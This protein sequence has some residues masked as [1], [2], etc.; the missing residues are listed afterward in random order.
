MKN[1]S[2]WFDAYDWCILWC[3]SFANCGSISYTVMTSTTGPLSL[4]RQNDIGGTGESTVPDPCAAETETCHQTPLH[5]Y[6]YHDWQG[7]NSF[8]VTYSIRY[9]PTLFVFKN[10]FKKLTPTNICVKIN[11]VILLQDGITIHIYSSKLLSTSVHLI[12][13][14]SGTIWKWFIQLIYVTG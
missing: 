2:N 6:N 1:V 14:I 11:H 3:I 5:E 7:D 4:V 8:C 10:I 13:V 9:Q 12:F